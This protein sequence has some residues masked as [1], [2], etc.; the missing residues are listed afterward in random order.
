ME[1]VI[2]EKSGTFESIKGFGIFYD[3]PRYGK[4][5]IGWIPKERVKDIEIM[6]EE[7]K[8][9]DVVVESVFVHNILPTY[10]KLKILVSVFAS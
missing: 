2:V 6:V 1:T 7:Y 8:H 5:Q 3:F 10:R 9:L 4:H